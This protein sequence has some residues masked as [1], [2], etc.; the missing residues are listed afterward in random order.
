MLG[1]VEKGHTVRMLSEQYDVITATIYLWLCKQAPQRRLS[2]QEMEKTVNQ[3][4]KENKLLKEEAANLERDIARFIQNG[5]G[6][7]Y[8]RT[9]Q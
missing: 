9:G 2:Y 8:E 6:T 5:P 3:V 1:E 4:L 7:S